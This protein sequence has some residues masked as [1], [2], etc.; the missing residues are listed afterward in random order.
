MLIF[1]LPIISFPDIPVTL[2]PYIEQSHP[3]HLPSY[4]SEMENR[5]FEHSTPDTG[6]LWI[7]S[8]WQH[9]ALS[10]VPFLVIP[11]LL[12]GPFWFFFWPPSAELIFL[13]NS[14]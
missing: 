3:H 12:F 1:L 9:S 11:K 6:I 4:L 7:Y 5:V 13:V 8:A 10:S 2:V 14:R